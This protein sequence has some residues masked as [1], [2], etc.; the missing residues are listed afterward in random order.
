VKPSFTGIVAAALAA[1]LSPLASAGSFDGAAGTPGSLAIAASDPAFVGWATGFSDLVPGPAQIDNLATG[2]V[3]FGAGLQTLGAAGADVFDVVSL[4]DGGRITLTFAA[5]IADGP[6]WD[7]AAFENS[8]SNTFL[9]LAFV[10]VS[11][12]GTDFFR[13]D[14]FSETPASTQIG[15]FGTVDPTNLRNL[16]GKYRFGFGTPFDLAELAGRSSL[17]NVN[18][19]THVRIVDVV[20]AVNPAYATRDSLG[21]IINDPWATPFSS[22]GFDL[23][24]IGVRYT[25]GSTGYAAWRAGFFNATEL[26]DTSVS[27]INAD[28]DGDGRVNLLEYALGTA[29]RDATDGRTNEPAVSLDAG[30]LSVSYLLPEGRSDIAVTAEWSA[31][32][33]S[34]YSSIDYVSGPVLEMVP[35]GTRVTFTAQTLL[36]SQ[37]R[38]FMKLVASPR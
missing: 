33:L 13:F 37:P 31:D 20:G 4:G 29:P 10:E 34:W 19:V 9:E 38:Q 8:F 23:D 7:F 26:A 2:N 25:A 27:G 22:G 3:T 5:P 16:A 18:A 17:L 36:A 32:L 21:R 12:N 11:S 6:G 30:R 1:A 24:A 35:S 15:G 14:A 28:P